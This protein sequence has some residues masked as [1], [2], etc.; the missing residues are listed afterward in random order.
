MPQL[1]S[2]GIGATT[3]VF[4][5]VD[6]ILLK[7]MAYERP[8]ELVTIRKAFPSWRDVPVLAK[9]WDKLGLRWNEFLTL[10]DETRA[11]RQVAVHRASTMILSGV[12]DPVRLDVGEVSAGLFPLLGIRPV[13][14]RTFLPGEEGPGAPRLAVLSYEIW[15]GRFGFDPTVVGRSVTL[16]G[17]PFEVIGVLP[18]GFGIH[19]SLYNVLNSAIDTGDRALWVPADW[20]R[21]DPN[22]S[23]DL[24][25]LGRL[26]PG[27]TRTEALAEVDALLRA[28]RSREQIQFRLATPKEEVVGGYRAPLLL[29]L[30]ASGLLLLIACSNAA[31]LLLGEAVNR[32]GKSPPG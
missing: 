14:G 4:S 19:S 18:R 30:G 20:D 21:S 9:A 23:T 17:K 6:G 11:F 27:V 29:L 22:S 10:R 25:A 24:E 13:L 26:R 12:G 1:S 28:E 8:G 16:S 5:L 31:T 2:L 15:Q 7:D 3:T 32:R